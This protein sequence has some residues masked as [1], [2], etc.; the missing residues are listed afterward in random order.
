[1]LY[2]YRKKKTKAWYECNQEEAANLQKPEF[3]K[4]FEFKTEEV[5]DAVPSP[6][7]LDLPRESAPKPTPK[8][9]KT[10]KKID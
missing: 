8:K 4:A 6:S 5:V 2:F 1:M 3:Q 7:A 10:K 9:A